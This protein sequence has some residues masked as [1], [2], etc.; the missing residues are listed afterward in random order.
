MKRISKKYSLTNKLI[1]KPLLIFFLLLLGFIAIVY[2][3]QDSFFFASHQ[4]DRVL[5]SIN[6]KKTAIN[7]WF[8]SLKSDIEN[9]AVS[10]RQFYLI[11]NNNESHKLTKNELKKIASQK[12]E[13]EE[14]IKKL[15]SEKKNSS[16]FNTISIISKEGTIVSSTSIDLNNTDISE[17]N[18]FKNTISKIKVPTFIGFWKEG[19]KEYEIDIACPIKDDKG[20]VIAY[21]HGVIN[22]TSLQSIID[23]S[24]ELTYEIVDKEGYILMASHQMNKG[25]KYSSQFTNNLGKLS[26]FDDKIIALVGLEELNLYLLQKIDSYYFLYPVIEFGAIFLGFT[27]FVIFLFIYQSVVIKKEISLPLNRM[28]GYIRSSS[29]GLQSVKLEGKYPLEIDN[30]LQAINDSLNDTNPPT[31]NKSQENIT[32]TNYSQVSNNTSDNIQK[33]ENN[34]ISLIDILKSHRD[35]I[36][37]ETYEIMRKMG[38]LNN[39]D[40]NFLILKKNIIKLN[41]IF[42]NIIFLSEYESVKRE[43]LFSDI[44][45]KLD[46]TAR[47]LNISPLLE[48]IIEHDDKL[49]G[50]KITG[51]KDAISNLL[52]NLLICSLISTDS[53]TVTLLSSLISDD[54]GRES[55]IINISDTGVGFDEAEL[56]A[57]K[58]GQRDA[59][60]VLLSAIMIAKNEDIELSIDSK[61]DKGTVTSVLINI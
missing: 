54:D 18:I 26:L 6:E 14:S 32:N 33:K 35:K 12:M 59:N 30:L 47:S 31:Y 53:G 49:T 4:K 48:T 13:R 20:H 27:M 16:L 5:L 3:Y 56:N 7:I 21:I 37:F 40:K 28:V 10:L 55:I 46:K 50:K 29:A 15:L 34:N 19:V 2:K 57:I 61:K 52:T 22:L 44:L 39:K 51:N 9:L 23:K 36:G 25:L 11:D 42:D 60:P 45:D 38:I 58:S 1:K 41:C 17:T 43:F 24:K 8:K